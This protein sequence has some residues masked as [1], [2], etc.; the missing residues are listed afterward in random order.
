MLPVLGW[1]I[2]LPH[3]A[4]TATTTATSITTT[5]TTTTTTNNNNNNNN[6]VLGKIWVQ[7]ACFVCLEAP[8]CC[9]Y[10][11][12]KGR[13]MG[14]VSA[15]ITDR[16]RSLKH[17]FTWTTWSGC[18]PQSILLNFAF[19][20]LATTAICVIPSLQ[21]HAGT[22]VRAVSTGLGQKQLSSRC[23]ILYAVISQRSVKA[24]IRTFNDLVAGWLSLSLS[25]SLSART[26]V[27][28]TISSA[29]LASWMCVVLTFKNRASYI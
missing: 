23:A 19:S 26:S 9:G 12:W 1:Y 18:Q 10:G 25:L 17:W 22:R 27:R 11:I 13:I 29:H 6:N 15:L 20:V 16:C 14:H 24:S 7:S 2:S 28:Y 21:W 5:T 8:A 3:T 4:A